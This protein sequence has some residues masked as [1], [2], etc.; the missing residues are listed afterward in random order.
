VKLP[1]WSYSFL[2]TVDNCP[3]HALHKFVLRDVER[4]ESEQQK[5]GLEAHATLARRISRKTP[6][7]EPF[8]HLEPLCRVFDLPVLNVQTEL[9]LGVKLD[10]RTCDFFAPDV[11]GRGVI[12]VA[13]T[14]DTTAAIYD[15]KNGKV[16]EDP[17]ELKIQAVLLKAKYPK[18]QKI[19]GGYIW[20]QPGALGVAYDLSD[21]A[22][23]WQA[24]MARVT[25]VVRLAQLNTW[26][27]V[28]SPLCGWCE[29]TT[30]EHY[31]GR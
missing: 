15:W 2:S 21:T 24:I 4:R 10:G 23:H 22:A 26:P 16:R 20:L 9:K 1:P 6:L 31:R 28:Q 19:V 14:D 13:V 29:V 17:F 25:D 27:K 11:F 5:A 3:H 7:A 30:C 8:A 18:L 12:D